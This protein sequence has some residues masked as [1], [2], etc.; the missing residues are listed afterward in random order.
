MAT[1]PAIHPYLINAAAI[2]IRKL[3]KN[4]IIKNAQVGVDNNEIVKYICYKTHNCELLLHYLGGDYF[5][6]MM[7]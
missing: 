5:V 3:L 6:L 2:F 4:K 7:K 1:L